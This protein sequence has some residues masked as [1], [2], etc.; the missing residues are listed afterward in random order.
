[1]ASARLF[2]PPSYQVACMKLNV[3][4]DGRS[5]AFDVPD[6]LITEAEDFFAKMDADMDKGW[7]MSRDW[8]KDPDTEQ[9]CRIV[10]DRM[11]GAIESSNEKLL[12]L[13]CG[14]LLNR[15]PGI[16]GVNIDITGD[17]NETDL[18]M[19]LEEDGR[20]LGPILS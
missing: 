2:V 4:I 15:M 12:M 3:I 20:P 5:S 9:R 6:E 13:L 16:T 17:M 10:A 8:V 11:L 14:Y 7:Q 1:M 19:K 18:I